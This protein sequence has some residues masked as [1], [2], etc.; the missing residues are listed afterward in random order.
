MDAFQFMA[1]HDYPG[2][3][4]H[5]VGKL[6]SPPTAL[7]HTP[8]LAPEFLYVPVPVHLRQASRGECEESLRES[9]HLHPRRVIL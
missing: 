4:P 7:R 3:L 9:G 5:R 1:Q 6:T 8:Q 2:D